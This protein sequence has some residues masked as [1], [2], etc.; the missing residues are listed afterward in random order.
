MKCVKTQSRTTRLIRALTSAV[1]SK[2]LK[3]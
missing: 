1:E 2:T 3:T